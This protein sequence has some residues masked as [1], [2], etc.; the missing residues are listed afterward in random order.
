MKNVKIEIKKIKR[1][2][3]VC[4]GVSILCKFKT[5]ELARK[6]LENNNSFYLYWSQSESVSI[7]NTLPTIKII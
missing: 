5:E 2:W 4:A 7:E 6:D 1:S 3:C